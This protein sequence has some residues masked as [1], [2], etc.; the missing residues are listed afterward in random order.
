MWPAC[1]HVGPA[2]AVSCT[3]GEGERIEK[4]KREH[5]S[6]ATHTHMHAPCH[7]LRN[8]ANKTKQQQ[9]QS[10][11]RCF[12]HVAAWPSTKY[13]APIAHADSRSWDGRHGMHAMAKG[14]GCT[15]TTTDIAMQ[16]NARRQ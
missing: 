9:Q 5:D 15:K 10:R 8:H 12:L 14:C 6:M 7:T 2:F 13:H 4:R 16:G 11:H 1:E 3:E